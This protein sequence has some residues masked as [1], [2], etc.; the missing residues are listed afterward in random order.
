[1]K[2]IAILAIT[3]MNIPMMNIGFLKT[4]KAS[5]PSF[6]YLLIFFIISWFLTTIKDVKVYKNISWI[7][8]YK[9]K[10]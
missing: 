6:Y 7:F 10:T 2:K 9:I 4:L 3:D 8:G 5:P 1:M